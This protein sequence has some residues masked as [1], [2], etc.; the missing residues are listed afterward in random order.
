MFLIQWLSLMTI[1]FLI[2]SVAL[3]YYVKHTEEEDDNE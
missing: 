3:I 1:I 2:G